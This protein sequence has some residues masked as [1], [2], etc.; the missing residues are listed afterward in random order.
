MIARGDGLTRDDAFELVAATMEHFRD[1]GF[2]YVVV[3][4]SKQWTSAWPKPGPTPTP[5]PPSR[6]VAVDHTIG[7]RNVVMS[8]ANRSGSSYAAKWPPRGMDV[9]RLRL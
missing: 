2:R 3:E 9:Y 6:T 7:R 4:A 8:A 5:A 1:A